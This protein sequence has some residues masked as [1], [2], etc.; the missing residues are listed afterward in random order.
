M[1]K[2][3]NLNVAVIGPGLMGRIHTNG[4]KR[5]N[6]FFDLKHRPVLKVVCGRNEENARAFAE[7]LRGRMSPYLSDVPVGVG[8]RPDRPHA[9][10]A[11]SGSSSCTSSTQ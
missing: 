6:D 9:L 5:A 10:Y 11:D 8:T 1:S 4:Y 7:I 2:T 3:K